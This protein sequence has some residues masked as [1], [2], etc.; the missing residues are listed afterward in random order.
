MIEF[1][2][3]NWTYIFAAVDLVVVLVA[4]SHVVLTKRDNRAALGW[5]GII[6]FAPIIGSL[7]YFTFGVNRIRRKAQ[8]LRKRES[9]RVSLQHEQAAAEEL[10]RA[11]EDDAL[12]LTSLSEFVRGLTDTP[13]IPGNR[14]VP[15]HCGDEAYPRMIEAIDAAEHSVSLCTYIFD[16]DPE[17]L[18][19]VAALTRARERGVEVRVLIDDVGTRYTF[20]SIKHALRRGKITF[21]TFL[22]T[23]VPG[24]FHYT[25]LRNH[26]KI[27]VVDGKIGFTG[28]MNIRAGHRLASNTRHPVR[29]IH[30]ELQGPIVGQLQET[31]VGDWEFS[32]KE[33]LVGHQWFPKL[34]PRG[35]MLCRGIADG[36][37]TR[38]DKIRFTLLGAI[39]C[40]RRSLTIITP[41][42]LP[43]TALITALNVAAMRG[44]NV[45][46]VLPAKGNLA[47][48]QWATTAQLWQVLQRGC[49]VFLTKMPFD[50]TKIVTVDDAWSFIGSANWDPRSLRLNF[51]F[52]VECYDLDFTALMN[53]TIRAR[54][55]TA[56]QITLRDVDSRPLFIRIRDGIAR[57]ATPYL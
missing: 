23:F 7:L 13:L 55:S 48:V 14:I 31:F 5:V 47:L 12:H 49:R 16:N 36:P 3:S 37:D 32:T 45:T 41:Y 52:N 38:H 27:M 17:G 44:V 40:A 21:S 19:F 6:W 54:L 20:P 46:I 1:L 10:A 33:L 56:Q 22:P 30:F 51:E 35:P 4:S 43:D 15:L 39:G 50:H 8:R 2:Q 25:N 29:D 18:E 53:E 9:K 26:R 11:L 34:H 42:F 24:Q 57:L 28:G